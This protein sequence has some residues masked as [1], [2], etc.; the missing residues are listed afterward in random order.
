MKRVNLFFRITLVAVFASLVLSPVMAQR[1]AKSPQELY[2]EI[3][4]HLDEIER[5]HPKAQVP[6]FRARA[7]V[8][9]LYSHISGDID[10]PFISSNFELPEGDGSG[11]F[12]QHCNGLKDN[13]LRQALAKMVKNH[14]NV[15]YQRAQDIIFEDLDNDGGYVECAYT[16]R[17]LKTNSEPNASDMNVE[18][19][20]PQSKG[21]V[22][23]AKSDL[24]HLFAT[25]SR[26][27][28]RRGNLPF[29]EVE[30]VYWEEGG[31]KTDRDVF[32]VRKKSRGDTAR[33]MFYFAIRYDKRI[34]PAQEAILKQW[35]KEDPV[36]EAEIQRN[37]RVHNYQNNRN[38][39]V[40][41]PEFVNLIS[42]F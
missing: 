6:A 31:S 39:F 7:A 36:D 29:G 14:V 18:H 10:N 1:P 13:A 9:K 37:N 24:H 4:L 21:A 11:D 12:Y 19:T 32:E 28:S 26:A 25:D 2:Q 30:S 38:P 3:K 15:S 22:G 16:G 35:H 23:I 20:W 27:N 33:A 8:N 42:D 40:D 41:K 34:D 17:K 5:L